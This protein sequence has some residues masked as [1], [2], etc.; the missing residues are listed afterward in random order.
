MVKNKNG[1]P[2][3]RETPD[4]GAPGAN[5]VDGIVILSTVDNIPPSGTSCQELTDKS[6]L[7]LPQYYTPNIGNCLYDT[8]AIDALLTQATAHM[9]A[10]QDDE[11]WLKHY[12]IWLELHRLKCSAGEVTG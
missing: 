5:G 1:L 2:E 10:A 7:S 4:V 11:T 6:Y 8:S 3:K 12:L 9:Q